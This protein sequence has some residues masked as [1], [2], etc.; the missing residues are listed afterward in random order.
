MTSKSAIDG[1]IAGVVSRTVI[2]PLDVIKIRLQVQNKF[3]EEYSGIGDCV[4]KIY[5][6]E[7]IRAFWK[8]NLSGLML[9]GSFGAVQFYT[10]EKCKS[11]FKN[12][13]V[14]GGLAATAATV[15]TYPFD[16]V[17]TQMAIKANNVSPMAMLAHLKRNHEL[18]AGLYKGLTP[19]IAQVA[20]YMGTVFACHNTIQPWLENHAPG[21]VSDF[22]S[23]ATAGVLGKLVT[24]PFDTT[25]K[26]M[27]I[28]SQSFGHYELRNL[29]RFQSLKHCIAH[30]WLNEGV[31]GFYNG[32]TIALF[33]SV[34]GT[35]TTFLVYGLLSKL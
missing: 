2:A 8:G 30:T 16:T 20:P 4:R 25:R 6:R 34:P 3:Y 23:G 10:F 32:L 29:Q 9:Y 14:S 19:T 21:P 7:G 12:S 1:A 24:M 13:F 31:R 33:K 11:L 26:R 27:Q 35:A 22:V 5:K 17:R 18:V 28:Q 15:I